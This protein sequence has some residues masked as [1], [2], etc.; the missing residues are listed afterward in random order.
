[1]KAAVWNLLETLIAKGNSRPG[2]AEKVSLL[3][4]IVL[5]EAIAMYPFLA[6]S[7][8]LSQVLQLSLESQ[9]LT[10]L[11]GNRQE[12]FDKLQMLLDTLSDEEANTLSKVFILFL[13][14]SNI[15][16]QRFREQQHILHGRLGSLELPSST[17]SAALNFQ[18]SDTFRDLLNSFPSLTIQDLADQLSDFIVEFVLTAHPTQAARRTVLSKHMLV[19]ES[20]Q[21]LDV[22]VEAVAEEDRLE[23]LQ[24]IRREVQSLL[25][26]DP[27]RRKAPDPVDEARSGLQQVQSTLWDAVPRAL[28]SLDNALAKVAFETKQAAPVGPVSPI[29]RISSW[30]AG[31]RDGNPNVTA[32]VTL[33]VLMY[34]RLTGLRLFMGE[35]ESLLFE[36]SEK[37]ATPRFL[38]ISE[39]ASKALQVPLFHMHFRDFYSYLPT[40]EPYRFFL[41]IIRARL[42]YSIQKMEKRFEIVSQGSVDWANLPLDLQFH[43]DGSEYIDVSELSDQLQEMFESLEESG[44]QLIARGRLL[45]N[46]RRLKNFGLGV[47]RL[48]IRQDS[49]FHARAMDAVCQHLGWSAYTSWS[50]SEKQEFLKRELQSARPMF[51]WDDV[52]KFDRVVQ[53]VLYTFKMIALMNA[54]GIDQLSSYVISMAMEPSD[55]LLVLLFQKLARVLQPLRIAPLFETGEAL[56]RAPQTIHSLLAI[57]LYKSFAESVGYQEVMIGYSDSSRDVGRL[58]ADWAIYQAQENL[59]TVCGAAGVRLVLFHGRG[60]SIGRGGGAQH[61]AVFSQPPGSIGNH[62]RLTIQGETIQSFF[63][64]TRMCMQTL[65]SYLTGVLKATVN[66]PSRI[67]EEQRALLTSL[68]SVSSKSFRAIVY[69]HPLFPEYFGTTTPLQYIGALNIGSRPTVRRQQQIASHG[70]FI[71]DVNVLRAIPWIFSWTQVHMHL[72]VWLG[73]CDALESAISAG[74]LDELKEFY[75]S[76][77]LFRTMMD[78]YLMIL[79]KA[80]PI[81]LR[82]YQKLL[83]PQADTEMHEFGNSLIERLRKV[84]SLVA[85]V[86]G[87][88]ASFRTSTLYSSYMIRSVFLFPLNILQ[89]RFISSLR[90]DP[91]RKSAEEGILITIKGIAAGMR[92]TG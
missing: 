53:E 47:A 26:S 41:G 82:H 28:R 49:S 70:A 89:A 36:L 16:E 37:T 78:L 29:F 56:S 81:I 76:S 92:N 17:I 72:P 3:S 5:E 54:N 57:P 90:Q 59:I 67:S 11:S 66:P 50:E 88:L 8:L 4:Q 42:F 87:D 12:Q 45:D 79:L 73:V 33:Q 20:L 19:Y 48:D 30:I 21:K 86:A 14:L 61:F 39:R 84:E 43:P 32:D 46:I 60:G 15:A 83:V 22:P 31:D 24:C 58:A 80:D 52:R 63:G 75:V 91:S 9:K 34:S 10:D 2:L 1:M 55:V 25:L 68:S 7:E 38:G 65:E 85:L 62:L 74:R 27:I 23:A 44:Y 13:D 18:F 6:S 40:G 51:D 35:I 77:P 64:T 71:P 69:E